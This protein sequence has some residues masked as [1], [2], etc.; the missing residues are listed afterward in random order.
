MAAVEKVDMDKASK[1]YERTLTK[2]VFR[3]WHSSNVSSK[4]PWA[5]HTV[6]DIPSIMQ[7]QQPQG[8]SIPIAR[9]ASQQLITAEEV[10]VIL[11][12]WLYSKQVCYSWLRN[13]LV[14]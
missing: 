9:S 6:A 3:A 7:E 14:G 2:K 1:H 10:C 8:V 12:C 5:L 4:M 13:I 11:L